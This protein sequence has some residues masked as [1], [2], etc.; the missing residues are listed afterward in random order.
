MIAFD[1]DSEK[2]VK[3]FTENNRIG[4]VQRITVDTDQNVWFNSIGGYW[5][6]LRKRDCIIQFK[7]NDGL[8]YND[9]GMFYT[10]S[11]GSV[12]AGGNG[13]VV[14]FFPARLKTYENSACA[15]IVDVLVNDQLRPPAILGSSRQSVDL[16]PD[17][18]NLQVRFD[19]TNYDRWENNLFYYKLD[20]GQPAW[21]EVENGKL[22]FINLSP[23]RYQLSVKGGNKLTGLVTNVDKLFFTIQPHWYQRWEFFAL[24]AIFFAGGIYLA[25]RRRI[26]MIRKQA[27]LQQ[28]IA[29][30]EMMALRAQMNPHFIFN[31]LNSIEYYILQN[32]KRNASIYLNK[33]ASLIR[34]I[35]SNSRKDAVPFSEDMYTIG[36][37]IDL[38]LLRFNHNFKLITDIDQALLENDYLVP[39]L[40]IQPFVENA[41]IHGFSYSTRN[42][43]ML[44]ITALLRGEY[45]E[46]IIE[47]NGVGRVKSAAL[48]QINKPN[49][50]SLG[51]EIIRQRIALFHE[52]YQGTG[53]LKVDDLYDE[54]KT[55]AGTRV[56][57]K[58]KAI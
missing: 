28:K 1:A 50:A 31:C 57:I 55:A 52:Q 38:E 34:M 16:A 37:Y 7:Y 58:I 13:G 48:N 43:L 8:P 47:D 14:K 35:L 32:E 18:N 12:Y 19:I 51:M 53:Y 15:K 44:K 42:D 25:V 4:L 29:E 17:Q 2:I 27:T 54:N 11:D 41:I 22:S 26:A 45:I 56:T 21:K 24:C 39:P 5:C 46:Y 10:A 30:T 36:I 40:M 23:G 6:W 49:H 9:D 3:T 20:P 33:F